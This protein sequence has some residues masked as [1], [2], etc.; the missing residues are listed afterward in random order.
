MDFRDNYK[1]NTFLIAKNCP[2]NR[3]GLIFARTAEKIII[4]LNIE[5]LWPNYKF[6]QQ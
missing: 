6:G 3:S 2:L 4:L 5:Y 1:K